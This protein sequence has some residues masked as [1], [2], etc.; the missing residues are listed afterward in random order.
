M[1]DF[2]KIYAPIALVFLIAGLIAIRIFA[3]PPPGSVIIASGNKS[4]AYYAMAEHY[5]AMLE[6]N[7]I[8][9]DILETAGTVDN[10]DRLIN[11]E[12]DIALAQGGVAQTTKAHDILSLGAIYYEPLFLFVR[13]GI[14]IV[15]LRELEGIKTAIGPEGS[16]TRALSVTLLE[17]NGLDISDAN[18]VPLSGMSAVEA[19]RNGEVEAA[20]FVAKPSASYIAELINDEAFT[21][22]SLQR[23]KGYAQRFPYLAAITLYQG[24]VDPA[25]NLPKDDKLLVAPA[26]QLVVHKKLHPAIQALLVEESHAMHG[27]GDV[28][29]KPGDFPNRYLIDLPLSK[30]AKRYFENGPSFFR[31]MFSF[32]VANFLER[33]WVLLI[34]LVTLMIPL[35]N[36]APPVYRW[37]IRRKIYIWYSDLRALETKGRAATSEEELKDVRREL[38]DL[39]AETGNVEVPLSYTDDLYRLRSHIDLVITIMRK[40][41]DAP[42]PTE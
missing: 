25:Q 1:R 38:H 31:S 35:V 42:K 7:G 40:L 22:V 27:S 26:A 34:P 36:A 5:A 33:A 15:Q 11:R 2:L 14:S 10:F 4:G 19:L 24:V 29:S 17:D 6:E 37:R 18:F 16:G 12:A 8:K 28:L 9:A 3:P 41:A 39:Q 32:N 20:F 23:H 21:L 13:N 30:E